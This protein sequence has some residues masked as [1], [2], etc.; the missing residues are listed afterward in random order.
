M[1]TSLIFMSFSLINIHDYCVDNPQFAFF[2]RKRL[3]IIIMM[4]H[5]LF[6]LFD[7]VVNVKY[8]SG[9]YCFIFVH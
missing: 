3:P 4:L 9:L 6:C 2:G 7:Y 5:H 1:N 8:K